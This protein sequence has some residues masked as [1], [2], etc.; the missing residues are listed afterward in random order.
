VNLSEPFH[1]AKKN[2]R[3]G[4]IVYTIPGFPSAADSN[5]IIGWMQNE[6][7]VSIIENTIPVTKGFSDHANATI[8]AAHTA[9]T[10]NATEAMVYE[11]WTKPSLCVL[12]QSTADEMTFAGVCKRASGIFDGMILEWSE[13]NEKPYV[14]IANQHG[15]ELVQCIGPW[16][17]TERIGEIMNNV[18]PGGLVYLMSAEMTGADLFSNEKLADC[19]AR[20][21]SFRPD[22][23]VA[24]GFGVRTAD[25]VRTLAH[26]PGLDGVIIGTEFLRQV[27]KGAAVAKHYLQDI[28]AALPLPASATSSSSSSS[29]PKGA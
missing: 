4:L 16:H 19:I 22:I 14:D 15:I 28:F 12:Y 21:R 13:P 27:E 20:A 1:K 17:T 6:D 23:V 5:E 26:V 24:A 10:K 25:H 9:A 8:R 29:S 2:G 7:A 18:R 11:R 3:L